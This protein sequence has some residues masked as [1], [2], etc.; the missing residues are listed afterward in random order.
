MSRCDIN[1]DLIGAG[2][3]TRTDTGIIFPQDFKSWAS[4]IPPL[5]RCASSVP[6]TVKRRSS[7]VFRFKESATHFKKTKTPKFDRLDN[8]SNFGGTDR[9]RTDV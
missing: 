2:D 6:G 8:R 4:A 9:N 1:H 5:R 3:R 7:F